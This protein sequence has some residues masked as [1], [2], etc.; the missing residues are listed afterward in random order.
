MQ[1]FLKVIQH[2]RRQNYRRSQISVKII[3]IASRRSWFGRSRNRQI[4]RSP[5]HGLI[6]N[7][8]GVQPIQVEIAIQGSI[9]A[10]SPPNSQEVTRIDEEVTPVRAEARSSG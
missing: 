7:C 1:I 9:V 4:W 6:R 2:K 10:T 5:G 3:I 8:D